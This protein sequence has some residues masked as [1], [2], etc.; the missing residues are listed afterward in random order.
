M[1]VN[2]LTVSIIILFILCLFLILNKQDKEHFDDTIYTNIKVLFDKL[3]KSNVPMYI[4]NEQNTW[5][6]KYNYEIKVINSGDQQSIQ[7]VEDQKVIFPDLKKIDKNHFDGF[8]TL[9]DEFKKTID[10]D[11][12]LGNSNVRFVYDKQNRMWILAV[13]SGTFKL[14]IESDVSAIVPT[15]ATT[16][17]PTV[18]TTAFLPKKLLL[19]TVFTPKKVYIDSK[20][21]KNSLMISWSKPDLYGTEITIDDNFN[22]KKRKNSR[23]NK[24]RN[25]NQSE[26]NKSKI[27][28]FIIIE[29]LKD[30]I[31]SKKFRVLKKSDNSD[32]HINIVIDKQYLIGN[33]NIYV[34]SKF[35]KKF[36][37]N[38]NE[39]IIEKFS[40]P[41]NIV[42]Y[43]ISERPNNKFKLFKKQDEHI[44]KEKYANILNMLMGHINKKI[45]DIIELN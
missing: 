34:I 31:N 18:P 33:N 26:F 10:N 25:I 15:K 13:K 24:F 8:T 27:D 19:E 17:K 28:Y 20:E 35:K 22:E 21:L 12:I 14:Y 23:F 43:I 16:K 6:Q 11:M 29:T 39:K 7:I 1:Y 3:K 40:E 37:I 44:D 9:T 5:E 2:N 45:P 30:E 32:K 38:G 41:S 4:F 42:N 36:T